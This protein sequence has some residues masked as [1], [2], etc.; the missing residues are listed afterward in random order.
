[1]SEWSDW[2]ACSRECGGGVS[3][4]TRERITKARKGGK[5]CGANKEKKECNPQPCS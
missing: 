4:R 2:S 5:P 1:M 3:R